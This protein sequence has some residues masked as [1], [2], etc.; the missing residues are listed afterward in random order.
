MYKDVN[1]SCVLIDLL[2]K[3][4]H[5]HTLLG[6]I[7]PQ[8]SRWYLFIGRKWRRT[9]QTLD[10]GERGE[11][12]SQLKIQYSETKIMASGPIISWQIDGEMWKQW[13]ILFSWAPKS[14][15]DCDCSYEIIRLASWKESYD[16][17]RP[18][19]KKQRYQPRSI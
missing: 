16:K 11:W 17:P 13:Q 9:K 12:K 7:S 8:I 19:I 4:T 5:T 2:T 6:E 3:H 1:N 18:G 10:E 15:V 14:T